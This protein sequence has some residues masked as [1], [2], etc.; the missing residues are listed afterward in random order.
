MS[1]IADLTRELAESLERSATAHEAAAA[2]FRTTRSA[3]PADAANAPLAQCQALLGRFG[4]VVVHRDQFDQALHQVRLA[5]EDD[6]ED[7]SVNE[8]LERLLA[9]LKAQRAFVT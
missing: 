8:R 9:Y 6:Y 5:C 3:M 2:F 1:T 7:R 4:F